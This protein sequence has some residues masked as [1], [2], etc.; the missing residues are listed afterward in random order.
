MKTY[1]V[2]GAVRDKLLG[3]DDHESGDRDWVIVG[4]DIQSLLDA[5]YQQVGKDFP[6][7][8]HPD[9]KEE[10]ALARTERKSGKGYT[11]FECISDSSITL[12]EDL[13]RRDL[14]I[15]AI[16]QTAEGELIDYYAG[17][18][19]LNNRVLRHVSSA[20][21]E[22]PLRVLRVARFA[23]R[24]HSLGFTIADETMALMRS[25]S[26][27]GELEHLIPERVW[28]ETEKA[29]QTT[30]PQIYFKTLRE[31][32]ALQVLFPE[33]DCLFG[34]PQTEKHHPEIDTGIHTLMVL[35]QASKLSSVVAVR[36]AALT[37]DLGKGITPKTE[38]PRHIAHESTGKKLVKKLCKRLRVPKDCSDLALLVCEFHLHSHRAFE[39]KPSTIQK[40]FKSLDLYRRP[41]RL[42]LFLVACEAD[43]RGR[44]GFENNDYPQNI[45]LKSCFTAAKN[46]T[47]KTIETENLSGKEIGQAIDVERIRA[48][49]EVKK[50]NKER[51]GSSNNE[52]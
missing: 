27:E 28:K 36:F 11:G 6:V 52:Q 22:D 29:L 50:T 10:Y 20:F 35:E 5:G 31:C 16:A 39:L 12:K 45:Y 42:D 2:G 19:D 23:A 38:W 3:I 33:I 4:G 8:L 30:S 34:V 43:M 25:M 47:A 17:I 41:E 51:Q 32:D 46:I 13:L 37:H 1:L 49:A 14:T 24:F 18:N 21:G 15:N 9:S 40:L 44:K 48:I 26:R 7:F